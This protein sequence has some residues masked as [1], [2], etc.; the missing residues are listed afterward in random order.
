MEDKRRTSDIAE[1]PGDLPV[2]AKSAS[3]GDAK[4]TARYFDYPSSIASTETL[5]G[6]MPKTGGMAR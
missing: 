4:T 1:L 5:I 3:H 2:G 6:E